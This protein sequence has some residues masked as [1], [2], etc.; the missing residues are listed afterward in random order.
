V[1]DGFNRKH[2]ACNGETGTPREAS[3]RPTRQ[4]RFMCTL[5]AQLFPKKYLA[6][7]E[8]A[9]NA[10]RCEWPRC[11]RLS[12]WSSTAIQIHHLTPRGQPRGRTGPSQQSAFTGTGRRD[13]GYGSFPGSSPCTAPTGR[14]P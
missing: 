3:H 9:P 8:R 10:P 2:R 1:E 11:Q 7:H 6:L 14:P 13:G 5:P 4:G 12:V